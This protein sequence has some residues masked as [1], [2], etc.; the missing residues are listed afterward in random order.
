[1]TAALVVEDNKYFRK[2]FIKFM[3]SRFPSVVFREAESGEQAMQEL[4][5]KPPDIVF[6]DVELPGDNGIETTK[7]IREHY[8]QIFIV[9][10]TSYNFPEYRDAAYQSGADRFLVKGTTKLE[11]IAATVESVIS[12]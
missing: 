8:P 2:N 5:R 11:E 7:K 3:S 12:D 10:L 4:S 1:M 9:I 6:M